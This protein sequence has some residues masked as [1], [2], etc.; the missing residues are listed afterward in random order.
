[1]NRK[2]NLFWC[3]M[4]LLLCTSCAKRQYLKDMPVDFPLPAGFPVE[5]TIKPADRLDIHVS[6]KKAELLA[7]FMGLSYQVDENGE[8]TVSG[9][10]P[11]DG[12][13]VDIN[14]FVDFPVLGRL[15]MAGMT[16]PQASQYL[17]DLLRIGNYIPDAM[18][19]VKINNFTIYGLGALS[20]G[21]LVVK[22]G[23]ITILQAVAQ[24][25]DLT[26]HAKI[27][28]VR[29]IREANKERVEYDLDLTTIDT[30]Y[31]PAYY[32]Q[33]NDIIYAEPK[34]SLFGNSNT[35]TAISLAAVMAS[36]LYSI[37][38]ILK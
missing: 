20:P 1:M 37:A 34:K 15:K 10:G 26:Q 24:L 17:R 22:E 31:S 6:S 19:D 16:M 25:G 11:E 3:L 12:Y 29:V 2:V 38:F 30:Y 4:A 13:L 7:P 32:L 14:G 18:V 28:K 33:Q 35:T 27:R 36:I 8:T 9:N 21:K 5:T 23:R